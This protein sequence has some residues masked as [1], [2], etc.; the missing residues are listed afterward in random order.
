M[1]ADGRIRYAG[2]APSAATSTGYIAV[3]LREQAG[4]V[5]DALTISA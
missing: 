4:L 5:N 3:H 1:P 2:R